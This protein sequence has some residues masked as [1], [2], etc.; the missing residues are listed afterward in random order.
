M[1]R[2]VKCESKLRRILG[3]THGPPFRVIDALQLLLLFGNYSH[4]E[5]R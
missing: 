2:K 5:G 4:A 1:T 3:E